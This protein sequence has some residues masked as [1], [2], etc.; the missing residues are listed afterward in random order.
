MSEMLGNN[1]F[2]VRNYES[3]KT[4]FLALPEPLRSEMRVIKKLILCEI[5]LGDPHSALHYLLTILREIP[6]FIIKTDVEDED[7]PCRDLICHL[8][9]QP[10]FSSENNSTI[11]SMSILWLY[12]SIDKSLY[13]LDMLTPDYSTSDIQE[14]SKLMHNYINNNLTINSLERSL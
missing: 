10:G 13:Y 2:L 12:C 9:A 14:F 1:Y 6:D 7:C 4:T 3:A 11:L 5:F 8:E